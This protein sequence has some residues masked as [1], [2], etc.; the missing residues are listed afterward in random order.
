[1]KSLLARYFVPIVSCISLVI[2]CIALLV[3]CTTFW[4]QSSRPAPAHVASASIPAPPVTINVGRGYSMQIQNSDPTLS[5]YIA[6]AQEEFALVYPQL[7]TR[8]SAN[9]QAA[10]REITLRFVKNLGAAAETLAG[11]H[12]IEVDLDYAHSTPY[13]PGVLTHELTH[14]VQD[15]PTYVPW[16]TEAIANYSSQL[17]GPRRE[18]VYRSAAK[19]ITNTTYQ[20]DPYDTGARFLFWV[21]QNKRRDIVDRLNRILQA[22]N[23]TPNSFVQLTGETL[24][25]LW[26]EYQA[27]GGQVFTL[28]NKTPQQIYQSVTALTPDLSTS[29]TPTDAANWQVMQGNNANCGFQNG[30]YTA[31]I[32]TPNAFLPCAGLNTAGHNFAYQVDMTITQGDSG[33]IIG[34]GDGSAGLRF[35]VGS[36]GTFDLVNGQ[37]T[38]ISSA[39]SSAIKSG[40]QTNTLLMAVEDKDI[41][42]YV[43]GQYLGHTSD[44]FTGGG[45]FGFMAVDF[46]HATSVSY[47]NVKIWQW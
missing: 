31:S 24:D 14:V 10:P 5:T 3:S 38:L 41:Y 39:S 26:K 29:I 33:G 15:Y 4:A 37:A 44:T 11:Q 22:G 47:R 8:W 42:L 18:D 9:P 20:T 12:L 40:K 7:V 30:T 19:Y 45:H 23:Y 35:R 27:A 1:M 43:N 16:L 36:D 32:A 25:Q 17:Y 21:A 6:N 34:R 2:S 28:Q 13:D 46:G